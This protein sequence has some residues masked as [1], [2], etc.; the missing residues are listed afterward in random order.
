MCIYARYDYITGV[1]QRQV[2]TMIGASAPVDMSAR[3]FDLVDPL[4]VEIIGDQHSIGSS[5]GD[6]ES[7]SLFN[8]FSDLVL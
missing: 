2:E 3:L 5:E 8:V 1:Q 6:C 7:A 4:H